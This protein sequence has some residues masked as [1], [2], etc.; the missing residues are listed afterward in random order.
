MI[1]L[2]NSQN[3][4][5]INVRLVIQ[6]AILWI[7]AVLSVSLMQ[8][9]EFDGFTEPFREIDIA[10]P[11]P[12][13]IKQLA[14]R[15]GEHVQTGQV[16]TT[17]DNEVHTALLAIAEQSKLAQG[18]LEALQAELSLRRDRVEKFE[19]LVELGHARQ[20]E[21]EKARMELEIAVAQVKAAREDLLIKD[22]EY[23]KIKVQLDR[24]TIISPIDGVVTSLHKDVGE[25]VAPNAPEILTV[26]QLDPL[27]ATFSIL[28][29]HAEKLRLDQAVKI[30]FPVSK[31]VMEGQV[32]FIS[33]VTDAESGMVRVKVRVA[34]PDGKARSGERC[35][36]QFTGAN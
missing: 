8:A 14:V 5:H 26:V 21:I 24:R 33:P 17:L 30:R 36:I 13:I 27:L 10:S 34:N 7:S 29:P 35:L 1:H 31:R 18:R 4:Q 22:L 25:F 28:A 2:S 23:R 6:G 20:E 3:A 12:G 32:T 9:A 15:E 16:L 19:K 11:E